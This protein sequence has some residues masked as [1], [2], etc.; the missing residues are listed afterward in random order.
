MLKKN[1][2]QISRMENLCWSM[3]TV[4]ELRDTRDGSLFWI[5]LKIVSK[6]I[7]LWVTGETE[8]KIQ[9]EKNIGIEQIWHLTIFLFSFPSLFHFLPIL[10]KWTEISK[11]KARYR[12]FEAVVVGLTS[13]PK[14]NGA[15]K[16]KTYN[17]NL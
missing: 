16:V 4:L 2:D 12:K 5:D 10:R 11:T 15:P 6:V 1:T 14:Y 3:G 13:Q 9:E 7:R 17:N 8:G